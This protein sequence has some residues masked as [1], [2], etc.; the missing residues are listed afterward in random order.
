VGTAV[1]MLATGCGGA[2]AAQPQQAPAVTTTA[3]TATKTP[4]TRAEAAKYY[5]RTVK[6]WNTNWG[7]CTVIDT[8][9]EST[10][11]MERRALAACHTLPGILT[12]EIDC[13]E[14]PPAPW[15][16][17]VRGPMQDLLDSSRA[18]FYCIKPLRH[19]TTIDGYFRAGQSCPDQ[20]NDHSA[21]IVRA[22]LGLPAAPTS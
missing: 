22:H 17:E 14:H 8:W 3:S 6:T 7:K 11:D 18:T 10:P 19:V 12:K 4:M 21:D 20:S 1:G 15:P 2:K 5:L 13:F 16:A 9:S